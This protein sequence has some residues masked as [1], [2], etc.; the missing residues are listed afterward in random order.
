MK[1]SEPLSGQV[2]KEM[3]EAFDA[4]GID[5]SKLF[6]ANAY[7]CPATE[8][9]RERDERAAVLACRPL[10]FHF[11]KQLPLGTQTLACGKWAKL[12]LTGNEDGLFSKRGFIDQKWYIK[13]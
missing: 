5:R 13:E 11:L 6:I 8:P 3:Q 7:A 12:A 10:L 2:G 9:R 1:Q 4:A